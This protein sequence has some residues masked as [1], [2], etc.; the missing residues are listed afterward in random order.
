MAL[1]IVSR[2]TTQILVVLLLLAPLASIPTASAAT[3]HALGLD[4]GSIRAAADAGAPAKY[5]SY[6]V[7]SW[8][9]SSGWAG[10][11][12]ALDTA[13]A[14]G[15][16]PVIYWYYWGDDITPSCVD[17]GCAGKTPAQWTSMTQQ[18]TDHVRARMGGRETL[19]VLENEFNKGGID[20][21]YAPTFDAKLES[22]AKTLKTVPGVKII[23]GLGNWGEA[24][25]VKF[26]KSAAQ[27]EYI[28]F[29]MMRASTRDSEASYRGAADRTVFLTNY[30]AE[31]FN[32]PSF[33]Y[34]LALSSYPNW[35]K[36]QGETLQA[37]FSGLST[38]TTG[39]QGVIYR[40]LKDTY[41]DPKNY[42]GAAE[43]YWGLKTS[44]GAA[45][46]AWNVWVA[47]AGPSAPPPPPATNAP[48]AFEAE[49]MTATAGGYRADSAAS[50]GATWNV[51]S[52]GQ[53]SKTLV[54]DNAFAARVTIVAM[55]QPAGG[56]NPQMTLRHNGANVASFSVAP[57]YTS[58][59]ADLAI[60]AGSS[61]LAV[62]YDNDAVVNGVDRNLIV[63]VVR[64]EVAPTNRAPSAVFSMTT[65]DLTATMD[66]SASSDPDGDALSY[67]W[68][69][70]DGAQSTGAKTSHA[71]AAAGDYTVTL[72][73][74]DGKTSATSSQ[75]ARASA[76]PPPPFSATFANPKFN[77]WWAQIEVTGSET[78]TKVCARIAG[79]AC[80]PIDRQNWGAWAK[81]ISVP[82]GSQITFTATGASGREITSA[83]Y[84]Y[85]A[86]PAFTATFS[87]S[88]GNEWW[89]Q[90]RVDGNQP[91]SSVCASVNGGACQ[92]LTLRSWG[93]WAA[94]IHAV[95]GSQIVF[96]ATSNT[97]AK[98]SSQAVTW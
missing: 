55:G 88:G 75:T 37:I 76:P 79:G 92:T 9:A 52:N 32:K 84:S 24:N 28:G 61:S 66:A 58:Y 77:D 59:Q 46:P 54:A 96:V 34:D 4:M 78:V 56:V 83:A 19:I 51:W 73:V 47:N 39:L 22:V 67:A 45:K 74:S 82:R 16:T 27:S 72:T 35:E 49:K 44:S 20:G 38:G 57:G 18:L 29:Q 70:G 33:L 98:A 40:S 8:I 50:G 62:V 2:K 13:V 90:T 69:F 63:D 43:S 93:A 3:T 87:P 80:Q 26:P 31:K 60:P 17:N 10:V 23:L 68:N 48:G 12:N 15:T 91:I 89:V 36:Q 97:G 53:L 94:S 11:D 14:T 64:V 65:R 41:M 25:W 30:I 95:K 6:W 42:Y 21:S 71:Y 85:A 5:G 86:A 7:G 81:S 1:V